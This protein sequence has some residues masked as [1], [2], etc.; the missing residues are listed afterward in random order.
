MVSADR[1][2]IMETNRSLRN[3][4]TELENLL[5]KGVIDEAV[6]DQ[7]HA[8]LPDESP[9]HGP[10]RTATS[11]NNASPAPTRSSPAPNNNSNGVSPPPPAQQ[12]PTQAFQNLGL[13]STTSPAPPSYNDT[14]PPSVPTR[15]K[16]VIAHARAIYRY[17]ASDARDVSFEKDDKIAV[18]EYMN[19]DWWMGANLRTGQEGIFPRNYVLV[20]PDQEKSAQQPYPGAAGYPAQP[21]YGYPQGPPQ[22]QN[23]YNSSVPPVAVA[24]GGQPSGGQ[25]QGD[26]KVGE[27]GKKF[28]KKL[29]NAAIFGA[30]ATI[31]GNIVNS[32]F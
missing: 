21:Q 20:E 18:H 3:I 13:N 16:P 19:Q 15:G 17:A 12:P 9:L 1:Q 23:P 27:Y 25:Q 28:G 26:G 22:Q 31:G 11:N 29:G 24:E 8:A 5:E 30:G 14:P 2:T 7:I 32:I 10:L 4:K 6:F